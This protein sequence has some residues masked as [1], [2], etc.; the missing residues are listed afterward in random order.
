[1]PVSSF[2]PRGVFHNIFNQLFSSVW[3]PRFVQTQAYGIAWNPPRI[4]WKQTELRLIKKKLGVM[5]II[6]LY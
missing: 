3:Q 1:M 2:E 6:N 5:F 4:S